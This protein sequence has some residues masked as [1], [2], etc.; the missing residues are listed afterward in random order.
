MEVNPSLV[1]IRRDS[2]TVKW[3]VYEFE[4]KRFHYTQR[5]SF[6]REQVTERTHDQ[7]I[8]L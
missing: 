2:Y 7:Y 8:P 6:E 4:Y 5:S 3:N 1:H